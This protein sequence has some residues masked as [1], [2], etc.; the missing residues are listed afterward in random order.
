MESD[1]PVVITAEGMQ[2]DIDRDY[3][4][5]LCV[6]NGM[7]VIPDPHKLDRGWISEEQGIRC[8]PVTLYLV[9]VQNVIGNSKL[10][11]LS[12]V[13][14]ENPWNL[15]NLSSHHEEG[16]LN[17][18]NHLNLNFCFCAILYI[19]MLRNTIREGQYLIIIF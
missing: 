16:Y 2:A 8:W 11:L 19:T 12:P 7:D 10:C 14:L 18:C 17:V 4:R 13:V 6:V 1:L 5:E 15:Q 9:S 3:E